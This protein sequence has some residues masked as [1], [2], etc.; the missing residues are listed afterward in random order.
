VG[1]EYTIGRLAEAAGVHVETIRYYE[2]RGLL[3]PP[4]RTA[5][6]YR[7]YADDDLA[8]LQLIARGKALGFTLSEIGELVGSS[9][10]RTVDEVLSAAQD[11]AEALAARQ[12]ELAETQ[13]RLRE[14]TRL[15][16]DGVEADCVAL[17][18]ST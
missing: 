9:G 6:G 3:A 5:S 1:R 14:L 11:K 16:A 17:R 4:A 8:L 7:I 12:V 13:R 2:R 10:S 15:C 18:V